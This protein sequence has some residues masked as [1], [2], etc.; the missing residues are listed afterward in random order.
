V[1]T[2]QASDEQNGPGAT[3]GI[4]ALRNALLPEGA[5]SAKFSTTVGADLRTVNGTIYAGIQPGEELR[6]LWFKLEDKLIPTVYTLWHNPDILPLLHTPNVVLQKMRAGADLMTPG[7]ARGPPFPKRATKG[8]VAAVASY[9]C[10]SVPLAVGECE[11][12]ISTLTEVRGAKGHAVRPLH[13]EGDELW[14]WSQTAETGKKPPGHIDGW[15]STGD[16]DTVDGVKNLSIEDDDDE[17][18]A[19]DGGVP[20][21]AAGSDRNQHVEGEDIPKNYEEVKK[22]Q[23][24]TA[25]I[26]D[27]FWKAFI[28]SLHEAK[29]IHRDE[30]NHGIEFPIPQS[31]LISNHVMP[32]LPI[33]SPEDAAN[34]QLKKTSWKNVKKF[35]K[36][37]D[38]AL[39]VKS[40]DRNGGETVVLDFDWT[41]RAVIDFVPYRL[42]KKASNTESSAQQQAGDSSL[43]QKLKILQLYKPKQKLGPIFD[44]SEMGTQSLYLASEIKATVNAYL[45]QENLLPTAQARMV[46]LDPVLANAVFDSNTAL[47]REVLANGQTSHEPML[48]RI[49]E[50]GC[51]TYYTILKNDETREQVK[52]KAGTLPKIKVLLETRSGNKTATRVSGLEPFHVQPTPLADELRK[53]CASSTSVDQLVGSSPKNPVMEI[54]I[55]GPQKDA[56]FKALD[57]RGIRKEW[58]EVTDKTKGKKGR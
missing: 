32:F 37:M 50:T 5:L 55:Q 31:Q 2:V 40:K 1:P 45:K 3:T 43:G 30:P 44:R 16:E 22:P 56:I 48:T 39:L 9:E 53:A 47:D 19:A 51:N 49:L 38:K 46:K 17:D 21:E 23:L 52:P 27:V 12:D 20:L 13:C 15:Y 10:P 36:A 24:S 34:L 26:D 7:L 25:E 41:D 33:F 54:M 14:A 42:P 4:T 29:R 57:K 11:I 58:I 18:E 6:I 8:A 35:I 28:Y